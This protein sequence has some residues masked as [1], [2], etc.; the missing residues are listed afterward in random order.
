MLT[1]AVWYQTLQSKGRKRLMSQLKGYQAGRPLSYWD[2]GQLFCSLQTVNWLDVAHI[3]WKGSSASLSTQS[4]NLNINLTQKH[5]P[6]HTQNSVW[7]TIWAPYNPV[8][9]GQPIKWTIAIFLTPFSSSILWVSLSFIQSVSCWWTFDYFQS[10]VIRNGSVVNKFVCTY[11]ICLP[12]ALVGQLPG[13]GISGSKGQCTCNCPSWGAV[14]FHLLS[15]MCGNTC[16]MGKQVP[17]LVKKNRAAFDCRDWFRTK[18]ANGCDWWELLWKHQDRKAVFPENCSVSY[19]PRTS[20]GCH[21][22][23]AWS[24]RRHREL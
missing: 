20:R 15:A 22:E 10:F 2:E 5:P 1:C 9:S 4:T 12:T 7:P 21:V 23:K 17:T 14:P 3:Q 11:Y 18:L 6:R 16:P 24:R 19:K 8:R 13:E